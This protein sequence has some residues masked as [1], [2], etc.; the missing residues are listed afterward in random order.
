MKITLILLVLGT[1]FAGCGSQHEYTEISSEEIRGIF[2]GWHPEYTQH[3]YDNVA[4]IRTNALRPDTVDTVAL[5]MQIHEME[6]LM[7]QDKQSIAPGHEVIELYFRP[8]GSV[9]S[10]DPVRPH[11]LH[12]DVQSMRAKQTFRAEL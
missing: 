11:L 6:W 7:Q 5:Q 1:V 2:I 10:Y 12:L 9:A 3:S 4:F 8:R